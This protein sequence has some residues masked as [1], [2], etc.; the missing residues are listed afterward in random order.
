MSKVYADSLGT[1]NRSSETDV[2]SIITAVNTT[3][4]Q[5]TSQISSLTTRMAAEEGKVQPISLGGTAA[6]TAQA[7]R[8]NLAVVGTATNAVPFGAFNSSN[9]ATSL[10]TSV[11]LTPAVPSR[12]LVMSTFVGNGTLSGAS[13]ATSQGTIATSQFNFA[14]SGSGF[15]VINLSNLTSTTITL[16]LSQNTSAGIFAGI[17]V[18][19]LPYS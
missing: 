8:T 7:A 16:N 5:Q 13:L 19:L 14:T 11:T 2:S 17:V 6:T 15:G 9:A 18:I 10:S 1:Q 4:P 3:I 12:A